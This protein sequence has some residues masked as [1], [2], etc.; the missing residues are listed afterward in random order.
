MLRDL[1]RADLVFDV[2]EVDKV[3]EFVGALPHVIGPLSG[4]PIKLEPFQV[5]ILA[6]IF[7]FLK[8]DTGLRKYREA[9]IL[10]PRGN[11]KSTLAAAIALYMTF[12]LGQGGA[13][14][15]SGATSL[16][17]ANAVFLPARAMVQ[18]TPELQELAG[19]EV[20]ARSIYQPSTGSSF[21]PVRAQTKDGGVVWLA[22]AD[23]LHQAIDGTQITAFRTGMGKRRGADPLLLIISTAGT[24]LAG[25]CRQEQ[26]YFESVLNGTISDDAKFALIYTIDKEDSWRDFKVWKK[27][28]PN[29][30]V[31]V[32]EDHLRREYERALQS[33]SAQAECLTK[34][35]NVW[36]NSASGWLNQKDWADAADASLTIPASAPAWIG[37]DLSTKTDI[38]AVTLVAG[39]PNGRRAIVPFLFLPE[40]ALLRSKNSKAYAEWVERGAIL[41]TEGSASDHEA[42]EQHVREL[43]RTYNVQGVLF[44]PWQSASMSQRLAAD[45]MTVMEFAQSA[46]NFSPAMTDFEAD[47]M[48]GRIVHPDNPVLNWM[49]ANISV[50][51]RGIMRS[52]VKPSGQDHLKIDGMVAALMAYAA[53]TAEPEPP[54]AELE[55]IALD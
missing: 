43:C 19:I 25:V 55:I 31:S 48:N 17:Q 53:S 40:G 22:I 12:M 29:Y 15:Y 13:E 9:F 33:P 52:P 54:P 47:L 50:K 16:D 35:L 11:A 20:A 7:G 32:D 30:G 8:R 6:N 36:C 23:E 1:E 41:M 4:E 10:L 44:D 3:C 38:T 26:L 27:A 5:F 24:N 45:G 28:N 34:Y 21:K 42:V 37:V 49:A 14:G 18:S 46:S 39:L 2:E 51:L